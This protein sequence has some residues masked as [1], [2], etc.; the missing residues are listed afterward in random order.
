MTKREMFTAILAVEAVAANQEMVDFINHEIELLNKKSSTERKPTKTQLENE[1]FKTCI[2]NYLVSTGTAHC[3]KE[4]QAAI[5]EIT[6]LSNQRITHLMTALVNAGT[7]TKEY[8]KKTPY[9]AIAN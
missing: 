7:V 4:I 9:Y 8:R 1:T 5:P 2:I 6:E 3:I